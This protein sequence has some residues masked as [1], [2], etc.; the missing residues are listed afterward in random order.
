MERRGNKKVQFGV[1]TSTSMDKTITIKVERKLPHPRYRKYVTLSKKFMAHDP[2]N[3]CNV[4]DKV[5]IVECR[6]LSRRKRWRLFEIVE[7]TA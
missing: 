4:G 5:R 6:P 1:V 7:R 2:E 3:S